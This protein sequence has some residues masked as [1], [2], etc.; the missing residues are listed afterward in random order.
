MA[1]A[2]SWVVAGGQERPPLPTTPAVSPIER[3]LQRNDPPLRTYRGRRRLEARNARFK[4]EGWME[5]TTELG[6]D[7]RLSWAVTGEG[8]SGYIRNRVL[9]K[10]LE[11]EVAAFRA[12]D[13]AKAAI[14]ES[15]YTFLV[16]DSGDDGTVN[17]RIEPRRR[18]VLLVSGFILL[19]RDD[20]DLVQIEGRL[21]KS[22]SFWTRT[23]DVIRRYCR[24]NGVLL[25][26]RL[27][28]TANVRIAGPSDF[29]MTYSYET[30]NGESVDGPQESTCAAR[31]LAR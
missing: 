2:M 28:S 20:G 17:V 7:Q 22:P 21:S 15:N 6:P 14:T 19:T 24:R 11:G 8:G 31:P 1:L 3:F 23:V 16:S 26:I 5:V 29:L 18:D 4:A 13:P 25:P 10:A 30:V 27:E 12:G 9:R